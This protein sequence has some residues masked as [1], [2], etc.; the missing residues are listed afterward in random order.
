MGGIE[1]VFT[2]DKDK[3]MFEI[4][5]YQQNYNKSLQLD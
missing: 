2:A 4:K 1:D 3:E 5:S